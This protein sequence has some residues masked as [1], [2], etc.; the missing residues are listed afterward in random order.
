MSSLVRYELSGKK[1]N[2]FGILVVAQFFVSLVQLTCWMGL[3]M[4]Q[5]AIFFALVFRIVILECLSFSLA[6][7]D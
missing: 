7:L 2:H 6:C 5:E 3:L 1:K 4:I